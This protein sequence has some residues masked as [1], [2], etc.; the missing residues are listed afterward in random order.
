[1]GETNIAFVLR[2]FTDILF[3]T[4]HV[5]ESWASSFESSVIC[6]I[7]LPDRDRVVSSANMSSIDFLISRGRSLINIKKR[8]GPKT[9]PFATPD[10]MSFEVNSSPEI[11]TV[12]DLN[13][14]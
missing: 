3:L 7:E 1:M 11:E 12:W 14:K 6:S 5:T 8:S 2:E 10:D 13:S 4:H 9:D